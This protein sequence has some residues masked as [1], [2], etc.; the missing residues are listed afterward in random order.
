MGP[1]LP[2]NLGWR[3]PSA[4]GGATTGKVAGRAGRVASFGALSAPCRARVPRARQGC[5]ETPEVT[6]SRGSQTGRGRVS[7][8][9]E[10]SCATESQIYGV[11]S[12]S[13]GWGAP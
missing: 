13:W 9:G 3:G 5:S 12:E 8:S 6:A 4:I 2:G 11:A 10:A 1:G 7:P